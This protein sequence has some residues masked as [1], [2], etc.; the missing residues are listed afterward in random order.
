MA[1]E[2]PIIVVGGGLGGVAAAASLLEGG[3]RV[4][5]LEGSSRF[6][7]RTRTAWS[8]AAPG[9]AVDV[10]GQW[11]APAHTRMLALLRRVGLSLVRQYGA[12]A[13]L[14]DDGRAVRRSLHLGT[15]I[16]RVSLLA[17]L[18]VEL[19]VLGSIERL[20]ATLPPSDALSSDGGGRGAR[21]LAELDAISVEQ[22]LRKRC[23]TN[24]ALRLGALTVELVLG[25]EPAQV[26]MLYLLRYVQQNRSLRFLVEVDNAAQHA[27]VAHGGVGRAAALLVDALRAE[28][29]EGRF[30]A[31]LDCAVVAVSADDVDG[32]GDGSGDGGGS[33]GG[34]GGGLL[35]VR[36]AAGEVLSTPHVV[37]AAPPVT[38]LQRVALTPAPP[39]EWRRCAE[40]SFMGCYTK[41]VALFDAPFWRERG[42]SGTCMRLAFD[43]EHPVQ[44]VYDHSEAAA[45]LE[46]L[47]P[48]S[49]ASEEAEGVAAV[50][51]AALARPPGPVALAAA[52]GARGPA[53][54]LVCFLAGD[55]AMLYAGASE[56][57]LHAAVVRSLVRFF[58]DE[59]R[60]R[61]LEVHS[62]EWGADEWSRGCPVN[63]L[64]VGN[65]ARHEAAMRTPLYGG[66]LH[67]A[68]TEAAPAFVGYMEGAVRA[69]EAAA[70]AVLAAAAPSEQRPPPRA[71]GWS[72][73]GARDGGAKPRALRR[74]ATAKADGDT[75]TL[76]QPL[77]RA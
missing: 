21:R 60:E 75:S 23:W 76:T 39:V 38:V 7:G 1:S 19:R 26:S 27:W 46:P 71:W 62:C 67:W 57:E 53:A 13:D 5:L 40:R 3:K 6:G 29:G 77:A 17:L 36:T 70:A 55:A 43:A 4:L 14:L 47:P 33:S 10:G 63:L 49:A 59:A 56:A 41:A 58:G 54:A 65:A 42:L 51:A 9:I 34:G 2:P 50:S 61:L 25:V 24:G 8:K 35:R 22:W 74:R 45:D 72:G 66:R 31:R 48:G 32:G 52:E 73:S 68:S 12:G 16:P 20:A 15:N 37:M 30:E 11:V 64:G 28:H 44:N 69:G 18:E